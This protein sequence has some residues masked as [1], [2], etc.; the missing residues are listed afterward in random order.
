MRNLF[1][2]FK[3]EALWLANYPHFIRDVHYETE[4]TL[5]HYIYHSNTATFVTLRL[6]QRFGIS[7]PSPRYIRKV[8]EAFSKG[9]FQVSSI[10]TIGS[11]EYG[12]LKSTIAAILSDREAQIESLDTDPTFGSLREP[13]LKVTSILRSFKF[14]QTWSN[15]EENFVTMSSLQ[16]KIG[17]MAHEAPDVF[18]FFAPEYSAPGVLSAASI[19]SPEAMQ[20]H[21]MI[22]LANGMLSLVKFG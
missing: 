19:K 14:Q 21:K 16:R 11:G 10:V 22:G 4:A 3:V 8:S 9:S 20:I 15:G 5:D 2:M 17:Q 7:D 18:S 6:I 1:S 12:D 13:L